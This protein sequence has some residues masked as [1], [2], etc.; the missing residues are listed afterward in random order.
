[1]FTDRIDALPEPT[2]LLLLLA[3]ADDTGDPAVV[4]AAAA[5]LGIAVTDLAPAEEKHLIRYDRVLAYRHPLIRSAAYHAA[6]LYRRLTAHQALAE[7]LAEA[8]AGDRYPDRRA[9]QLAAAS[10][11]P[12][13]TVAALLVQ[14]ADHAR[15]R[16][17][18]AGVAAAYERAAAHATD[19]AV[20]A[21]AA[22]VRADVA[23][24]EGDTL[25]ARD[26][27]GAAVVNLAGSH[28]EVSR[29]W[30][31]AGASRQALLLP[32]PLLVS[33]HVLASRCYLIPLCSRGTNLR[34]G[35]AAP[36]LSRDRVG[37]PTAPGT[38]LLARPTRHH[39][40]RWAPPRYSDG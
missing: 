4:F 28:P 26:I 27:L 18:Y 10:T 20:L 25:A 37:P 7:A 39:A 31:P 9:W 33:R 13:E 12:D 38:S 30:S 14:T 40:H 2:R 21:E 23:M 15:A 22:R 3:A 1:M 29:R 19:P 11:H 35:P 5:R 6:P 17:G 24:A 16:G 36:P 34:T 32:L 8:P